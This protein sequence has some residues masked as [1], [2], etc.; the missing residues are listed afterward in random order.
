[1]G[2]KHLWQPPALLMRMMTGVVS[3]VISRSL[4]VSNRHFKAVSKWNPAVPNARIGWSRLGEE[5]T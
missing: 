5:S 2:R 1:V 4:R 3:D